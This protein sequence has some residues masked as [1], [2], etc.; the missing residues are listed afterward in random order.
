MKKYMFI[1]FTLFMFISEVNAEACDYKDIKRLKEIANGVEITY[2]LQEPYD[3]E[4]YT[5][6][7][8]YKINIIG[9]T[10]ELIVYNETDDESYK[11]DTDFNNLMLHSGKKKITIYSS[12]CS[13]SLKKITLKLPVYND[14]SNTKECKMDKYKNLDMCQEWTEEDVLYEDFYRYFN[15]EENNSNDSNNFIDIIKNN[16][17]I[18]IIFGVVLVTIIILFI[19]KR[20]KEVLE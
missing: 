6:R 4:G 11:I 1:L 13:D 3:V 2:E 17:Y 7:D 18:V 5:Y 8:L 12:S 15:E 16:I 20:K 19:F 9:L 14:F 10:D